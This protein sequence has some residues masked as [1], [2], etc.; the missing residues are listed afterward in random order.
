MKLAPSYKH[1][2]RIIFFSSQISKIAIVRQIK[3]IIHI[4]Y[5]LNVINDLFPH[6]PNIFHLKT[7]NNSSETENQNIRILSSI[8]ALLEVD[9]NTCAYH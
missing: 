4:E 5:D 7:E 8:E 6:I 2:H 3:P 9:L 1:F